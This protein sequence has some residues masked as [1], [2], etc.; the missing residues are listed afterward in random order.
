[1]PVRGRCTTDE[2]SLR[3]HGVAALDVSVDEHLP[4]VT[5]VVPYRGHAKY[6][7]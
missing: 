4:F 5:L 7:D 6:N 3:R 2:A 1:M